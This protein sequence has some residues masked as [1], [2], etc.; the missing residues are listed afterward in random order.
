MKKREKI[1]NWD[2]SL[3]ALDKSNSQHKLNVKKHKTHLT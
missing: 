1:K 3:N 2:N